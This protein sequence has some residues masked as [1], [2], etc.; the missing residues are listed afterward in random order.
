[1]TLLSRRTLLLL[2]SVAAVGCGGGGGDAGVDASA[3]ADAADPVDG[4]IVAPRCGDEVL[5]AGE[6]CD[7]GNTGAGDGCTA[8]CTAIEQ[9]WVCAEPGLACVRT[10]LCGNGILEASETCDD[11]N[12]VAGDGCSA[13]CDLEAGWACAV[14]GIRCAAAACGDGIVAGFEQCDD[15]TPGGGDGCSAS[16]QLEPGYACATP[17]TACAVTTCGD[18]VVEGTEACDDGN[19]DLGDGCD[20]LCKQEPSCV[21][22]ACT[23]VCGDGVIHPTE[24]C[25]DGNLFSDDGCSATCTVEPGFTCTAA[26]PTEPTTFAVS[27]VFR[28]FRGFDLVGGHQDF[29]NKNGAELGIVGSTL[30]VDHKPVYVAAAT[31]LTTHGAANFASWYRDTAN[32]NLTYAEPLV[33]NRTAPATYVFDS[34]AFFPLDGRGFVGLGTEQPRNDGHNFHFT[35]ELRYWFEYKGGETLTFRGDDDVW[36][37]INRKLAIDLGGVHSP[38]VGSITL[39]ATAATNLDL[40]VGGTYE[41]VVF[42]A[43]RRTSGSSY[44]LTLAGFNAAKSVCDDVCGD[45]VTSAYEVCDD[46]VNQGGYGSCTA[47]CLGFGPRCGDGTVQAAHEQCDEGVNA[48][49]YGK[50]LPTCQLG[51][52]CGDGVIQTG[53][54]TCDDGNAD[55]LDGCNAC[56]VVLQ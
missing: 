21:A 4:T 37:F 26:N 5:D 50:C 17:N 27:T 23:A 51:P 55:P 2:L 18:A 15:G 39:N 52:R 49:G 8:D 36:V 24:G 38:L 22:G 48:G 34:Q 1:M 43:E 25:D 31:S 9:G 42:Q 44:K 3:A 29:Q 28:D 45:A 20:P 10:Q 40:T 11:R 33:L 13:T 41:V 14:P 30:G 6:V 56:Q 54:E 32:V 35:S 12:V 16:C 47:G 53:H 7:D 46:G 19:N